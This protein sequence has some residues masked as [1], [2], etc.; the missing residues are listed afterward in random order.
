[1]QLKERPAV[2]TVPRYFGQAKPDF[3]EL[4]ETHKVYEEEVINSKLWPK[5]KYETERQNLINHYEKFHNNTAGWSID[6]ELERLLL[7]YKKI[8]ILESRLSSRM[9][10][11]FDYLYSDFNDLVNDLNQRYISRDTYNSYFPLYKE[12]IETNKGLQLNHWNKPIVEKIEQAI[13]EL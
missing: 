12:A 2:Y 10:I 1:M 9:K 11:I 8:E 13:A 7:A 6:S 5:S 3:K 4:A